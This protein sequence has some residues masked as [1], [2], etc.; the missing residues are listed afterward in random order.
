MSV[1]TFKSEEFKTFPPI[2]REYAS[3]VAVIKGNSEKAVC[4][5]LL[6][7]RTF[8]RFMIMRENGESLSREEFQKISISNVGLDLVRR[9]I[10]VLSR[11]TLLIIS[12]L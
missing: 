8:F 5:Y 9:V 12:C 7:L 3:Y 11:R 4:E 10:Y 1:L 2:L 6:D